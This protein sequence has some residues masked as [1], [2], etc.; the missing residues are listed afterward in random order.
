[1]L[2]LLYPTRIF[3]LVRGVILCDFTCR[4]FLIRI[5]TLQPRT[6]KCKISGICGAL[7]RYIWF[8]I[9]CYSVMS[10]NILVVVRFV[11][12]TIA[13]IILGQRNAR[14][15]WSIITIYV[16]LF[17]VC[18]LLLPE[19]L[20]VI[21]IFVFASFCLYVFYNFI[22]LLVAFLLNLSALGGFLYLLLKYLSRLFTIA[23]FNI[24]GF[25]IK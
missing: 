19:I 16:S 9:N 7:S 4:S 1:M 18:F 8:I 25:Y 11:I 2:W 6:R 14:I 10:C 3:I 20:F 15:S 24:L 17:V 23:K 22:T 13:D 12:Y 21:R 5:Y